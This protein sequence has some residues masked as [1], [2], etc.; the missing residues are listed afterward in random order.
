MIMRSYAF[1]FGSLFVAAGVALFLRHVPFQPYLFLCGG[2]LSGLGFWIFGNQVAFLKTSRVA[3]GELVDWKEVAN[4][5]GRG[6]RFD[7]YAVIAFED[8]DG[9]SH[10]ITSATGTW[11]KPRTPM[12]TRFPV[13][14][15]PEAPKEARVDTVF[16]Y[17]GPGV[18]IVLFGVVVTVISFYAVQSR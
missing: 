11:P 17:W 3:S 18:L 12:G 4:S 14:Y 1:C 8:A 15:R 13:R 9:G 7:Y 16:D 6:S 2:G 10:R 5:S